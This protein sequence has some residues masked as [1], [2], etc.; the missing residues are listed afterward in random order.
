MYQDYQPIIYVHYINQ[1]EINYRL[2]LWNLKQNVS[3]LKGL[4]VDKVSV[5]LDAVA[6]EGGAHAG[7]RG[8]LKKSH[9]HLLDV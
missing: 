1:L 9:H 3:G 5:D 7:R 6:G 2:N 8:V 4:H